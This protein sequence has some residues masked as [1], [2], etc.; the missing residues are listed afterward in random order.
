MKLVANWGRDVTTDKFIFRILKIRCLYL[1]VTCFNFLV[2]VTECMSTVKQSLV[3]FQRNG[4]L[5]WVL[6][7][8]T[9][10]PN[11]KNFSRLFIAYGGL[12]I[13]VPRCV[14]PRHDLSGIK[15]NET[16]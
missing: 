2:S 5:L 15:M 14:N 13:P 11:L 9:Y 7:I 6:I 16:I 4:Q 1:H 10:F 3:I 8:P 12:L